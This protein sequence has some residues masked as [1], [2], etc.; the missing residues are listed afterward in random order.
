MP[1]AEQTAQKDVEDYPMEPEGE[2]TIQF[3]QQDALAPSA[4]PD[5]GD[6]SRVSRGYYRVR[7]ILSGELSDSKHCECCFSSSH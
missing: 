1:Y 5:Q 6:I 4:T 7:V 3:E 2:P